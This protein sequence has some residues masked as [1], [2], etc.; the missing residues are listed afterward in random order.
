M[1]KLIA[2]L[3]GALL[4]VGCAAPEPA[5]TTAPTTLPPET[6]APTTAPTTEPTEP[7]DRADTRLTVLLP[8]ETQW[9]AAGS[10]LQMLLENL[11]YQV[12]V[13]YA[14]GDALAQAAQLEAA[15]D[16]GT[17]G[18]IL[19]PVESAALTEVCL[20]AKEQEI[21]IFS[22][23][24]L[25]MDTDAVS[26]YVSFD[27]RQIGAAL[28]RQLITQAGLD[29]MTEGA[30]TAELFMGSPE[31]SSA[32]LLYQGIMEELQPYIDQGFLTVPSGRIAFE[33]TCIQDWD[34]AV[35]EERF[36]GYLKEYYKNTLP[37]MICT[38]DDG[39]AA[40]CAE[41]L[42]QKKAKTQPLITGIG[43][44]EEAKIAVAEGRQLVTV[45]TDLLQLNEQLV[46]TVD[47]VMME[48]EPETNGKCENNAISVPAY[49]WD[50]EIITVA[51]SV[52][53]PTTNEDK[54]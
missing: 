44:G 12:E 35:V 33:D 28:A 7:K 47:A 50:F 1:K 36:T 42:T 21:P 39:F 23:D 49:L 30:L 6:T 18:I 3:L 54:N 40:A 29:T 41:V 31:D 17:D 5:V 24:R 20:V 11:H 26:Y 27:Y 38:V 48:K 22:Y 15:L 53:E 45:A 46:A 52:T 4:L 43:A 8:E 37:D 34:S 32:L 25:L 2:V 14:G 16:Q 10:D 51:Q 13:L 19:A 9:S